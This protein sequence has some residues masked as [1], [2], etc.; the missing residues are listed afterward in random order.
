MPIPKT[1]ILKVNVPTKRSLRE[2]ACHSTAGPVRK[3]FWNHFNELSLEVVYKPHKESTYAF[4][5][6]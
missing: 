4:D 1:L 3:E 5:Y 6:K 2:V